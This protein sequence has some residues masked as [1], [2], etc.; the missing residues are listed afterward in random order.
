LIFILK[1]SHASFPCC[2]KPQA[3]LSTYC[4][5]MDTMDLFSFHLCEYLG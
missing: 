4:K 5:L 2:K 1:C 3:Y